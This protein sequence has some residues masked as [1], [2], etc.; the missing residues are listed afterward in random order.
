MGFFSAV[1]VYGSMHVLSPMKRSSNF[2]CSENFCNLTRY[3]STVN[4]LLILIFIG[5]KEALIF[6]ENVLF[7]SAVSGSTVNVNARPSYTHNTYCGQY[8]YASYNEESWRRIDTRLSA[9]RGS[10][11]YTFVRSTV[12]N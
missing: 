7:Q 10:K 3:L 2:N 11:I 1:Q 8:G 12:Q 6:S 5:T 9:V 4:Q